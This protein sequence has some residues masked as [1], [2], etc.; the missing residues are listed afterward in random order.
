MGFVS[1]GSGWG[2]SRGLARRRASSGTGAGA[3]GGVSASGVAEAWTGETVAGT[4]GAVAE[5]GG[6]CGDGMHGAGGRQKGGTVARTS[7]G[8]AG[9]MREG[10]RD[11]RDDDIYKWHFKRVRGCRRC[12]PDLGCPDR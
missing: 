11:Y 7:F 5:G 2:G 8:P 4:G 12:L 9:R 10:G 1:R 6:R 3:A